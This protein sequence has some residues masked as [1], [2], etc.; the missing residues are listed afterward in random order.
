[1]LIWRPYTEAYRKHT[2]CGYA[3]KLVCCY[4]D[5]LSKPVQY[6][7]GENAVEKF[8]KLILKETKY[9]KDMAYK[10]FNKT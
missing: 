1:M 8:L 6:F 7:R 4:D 9:C 10:P 5:K 2:D 3:Y